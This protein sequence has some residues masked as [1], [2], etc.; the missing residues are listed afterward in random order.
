MDALRDTLRLRDQLRQKRDAEAK[1]A[2]CLAKLQATVL[3]KRR[4]ADVLAARMAELERLRYA[5]REVAV[6]YRAINQGNNDG[7]KTD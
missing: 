4:E 1:L 7:D 6:R 3:R 2:E 5:E